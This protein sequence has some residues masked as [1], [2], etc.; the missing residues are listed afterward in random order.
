MG[1]IRKALE[2]GFS[3]YPRVCMLTG[4]CLCCFLPVFDNRQPPCPHTNSRH[5]LLHPQMHHRNLWFG[6]EHALAV[7]TGC[8]FLVKSPLAKQK[9]LVQPVCSNLHAPTMNTRLCPPQ[10]PLLVQVNFAIVKCIPR[11]LHSRSFWPHALTL[12][13]RKTS[14]MR[15]GTS[16]SLLW[17]GTTMV[18]IWIRNKQ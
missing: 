14:S 7:Q 13:W 9:G 5:V 17:R 2:K 4:Q 11:R 3:D 1:Y 10:R 18:T 16:P 6:K 12:I 15:S 8:R